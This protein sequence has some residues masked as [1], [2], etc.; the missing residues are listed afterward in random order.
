MFYLHAKKEIAKIAKIC[1]L[2]IVGTMGRIGHAQPNDST[3]LLK[4]LMFI[5]MPK[6][7]FIIHF[8]LEILHFTESCNLIGWKHFDS[9]LENQNFARYGIGCKISITIIVFILYY[10]QEKNNDKIFQKIQKTL[11][12]GHFGPFIP[13]LGK[14]KFSWEK[15]LRQ[16]LNI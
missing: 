15:G 14:N 12:L 3:N 9:L 5:C 2:H 13:N 10:F 8:F 4:T 11:F 1:K 6:I 7:N 16:F